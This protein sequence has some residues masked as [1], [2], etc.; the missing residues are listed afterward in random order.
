MDVDEQLILWYLKEKRDL[1]WRNT[2]DPYK[3]WLSEIILQ[4]TRVDQGLDYYHKFVSTYPTV[5]LLAEADTEEI[6]K[7]WQGLGYYSRARNLHATAKHIHFELEGVFPEKYASIIKL[8]GVGPY[9]AAA[10]ASFAFKE[11]KA[12]VDGNVYRVLSR[13]FDINTPINS[14]EGKKIFQEL[15][16][17]LLSQERPDLFNQAIMELGA[18][19]CTPKK[20]L[21]LH[22]PIQ[23][24]CLAFQNSTIDERPIKL[25]KTKQTL[26]RI[27]YAVVEKGNEI[28]LRKREEKD[29][30]Q[31]LYDFASLEDSENIEE[32]AMSNYVRETFPKARVASIGSVPEKSYTH[33]LSHRRIE[34]RFW[35]V[36]VS[37]TLE[38]EGV[39]RV[40]QK[41]D[42][43]KYAVP[44]LIHRFLEDT[45]MV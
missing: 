6:L 42:I 9:T 19:V 25:K 13:L 21:C 37:G 39:Y 32:A 31:G 33:L 3:I 11:P 22:C 38:D 43:D 15:A 28:V 16:D 36:E 12:V 18:L 44:R 26:R 29:I 45:G 8:K 34:A 4:Q 14:T 24:K 23:G 30:W 35:R 7:N 17:G 27:D 2:T 1:P 20:P 41:D 5:G 10:I 40:I